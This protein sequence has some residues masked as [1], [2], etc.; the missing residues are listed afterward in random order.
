MKRPLPVSQIIFTSAL[1][2]LENLVKERPLLRRMLLRRFFSVSQ[3]NRESA[4]ASA[5][6]SPSPPLQVP[7]FIFIPRCTKTR[8][9]RPS[10]QYGI[11]LGHKPENIILN[12]DKYGP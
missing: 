5:I 12:C 6:N 1:S 4:L 8:N 7:E 10:L 9:S 2:R 3:T 11:F